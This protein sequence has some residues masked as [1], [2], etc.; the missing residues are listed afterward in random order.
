MSVRA[1]ANERDVGDSCVAA[2]STLI[3]QLYDVDLAGKILRAG[4][5]VVNIAQ[6]GYFY[7]DYDS[8]D[9]QAI[10]SITSCQCDKPSGLAYNVTIVPDS[11][12][13]GGYLIAPT[14]DQTIVYG[15]GNKINCSAMYSPDN[16]AFP[17]GTRCYI[18]INMATDSVT[19]VTISAGTAVVS[20]S[21]S[22]QFL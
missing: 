9:L 6:S 22:R 16:L 10:F 19:D 15:G 11:P 4:A 20:L 13:T 14:Y 12:L 1:G 3:P 18:A 21:P 8:T 17:K 5:G 2:C 7:W